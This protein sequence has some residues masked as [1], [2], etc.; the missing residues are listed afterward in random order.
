VPLRAI[1]A[2]KDIHTFEFDETSW[3]SLKSSYRSASLKMPC[4]GSPAIPKT[5]LLGN[6][7]FAHTKKGECTSESESAEHLYI[8]NLIAKA[9]S[10]LGWRV[11]TEKP[12]QSPSGDSWIADVLCEKANVQIALE[13]Q[14]SYQTQEVTLARQ[15]RYAES[16]VR[17]LWLLSSDTFNRTYLKASKETPHFFL[18]KIAIGKEPAIIEFDVSVVEFIR[19][20]LTGKLSWKEQAP[21]S[22]LIEYNIEFFHDTCWQCLQPIKQ[23]YGYSIDVYGD[24]AKTIPNASAIL[25]AIHHFA[26]NKTLELAGLNSIVRIDT[27]KGKNTN[28]PFCNVCIH[29]KAPQ[30]NFDL[31]RKLS[32]HLEAESTDT[33][34]IMVTAGSKSLKNGE[35]KFLQDQ[36]KKTNSE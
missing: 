31:M 30:N 20:A 7:F 15:K 2:D 24:R 35:W 27:I 6:F 21:E 8:K 17:C 32:E 16:G 26:P 13:V 4:C 22:S 9:A 34:E 3:A 1:S 10:N 14:L 25:E 19:G 36:L 12:G 33:T 28:Y 5:S 23:I 18:S 29:C 11:T